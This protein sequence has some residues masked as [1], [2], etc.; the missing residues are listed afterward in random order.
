MDRDRLAVIVENNDL[1]KPTG[2]V[3]ADVE[4]ALALTHNADSVANCVLDVLV[5]NPVF[6]GVIRNLH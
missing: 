3:R 1:K 5:R 2:P 6:A 4:V